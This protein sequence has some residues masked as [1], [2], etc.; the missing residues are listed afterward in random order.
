MNLQSEFGNYITTQT[1]I[2]ALYMQVG[3]KNGQ[4]DGRT[5]Q[6]LDA[7]TDLSARG[8]KNISKV[9]DVSSLTIPGINRKWSILEDI[10]QHYL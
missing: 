9:R 1:L 3:R 6:L 8:H 2:N 10:K 7:P 4:T 5:I